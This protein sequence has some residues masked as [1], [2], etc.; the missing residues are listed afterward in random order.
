[1][2]VKLMGAAAAGYELVAD[3]KAVATVAEL[4]LVLLASRGA[5]LTT[6]DQLRQAAKAAPGKF[7]Y[8]STGTADR[9][10][11]HRNLQAADGK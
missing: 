7:A 2:S 3:F 8:G 11:R 9:T 6:L 1:M 5:G 10:H 4:P